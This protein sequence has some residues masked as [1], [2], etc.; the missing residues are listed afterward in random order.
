MLHQ[1]AEHDDDLWAAAL[2]PCHPLPGMHGQPEQVGDHWVN[3]I[4]AALHTQFISLILLVMGAHMGVG[5]GVHN[6]FL[7]KAT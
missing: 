1:A 5:A 6:D 7:R 3:S 4:Q 2:P